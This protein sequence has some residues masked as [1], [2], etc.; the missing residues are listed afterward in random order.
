ME[1]NTQRKKLVMPEYGRNIQKM[2]RECTEIEDRAERTRNAEAIVRVMAQ[3]V[4]K[5]KETGEFWQKLWD[6]V[7]IISDFKLDVDSPYPMPDKEI[8]TAKPEKVPYSENNIRYLHY[9]K[10]IE[11]IIEKAKEYPEG[12]EKDALIRTIANHLK[13]S[14]L[15][16]N[17]ESVDDELILHHLKD[18]SGGKLELSESDQL[19]QTHAILAMNKKKKLPV[20]NV[21][22]RRK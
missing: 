16:W 21:R 4:P 19:S 2:I 15:N 1:Y 7:Y 13:K 9:G 10:N 17:R 18:L 11:N 14:Y 20:K 6:H 3:M 12:P 22:G 8:L 5:V